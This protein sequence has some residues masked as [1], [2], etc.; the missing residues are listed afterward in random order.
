[1]KPTSLLVILVCCASLP[2]CA[3]SSAPENNNEIVAPEQD[4]PSQS[5]ENGEALP[6]DAGDA[7]NTIPSGPRLAK[8]GEEN[9]RNSANEKVTFRLLAEFQA[10]DLGCTAEAVIENSGWSGI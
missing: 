8:P 6:D 4:R 10:E 3:D 9:I 5:F 1:M 7:S 2:A